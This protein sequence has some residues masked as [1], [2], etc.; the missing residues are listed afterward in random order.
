VQETS[1][2][3][4]ARCGCVRAPHDRLAPGACGRWLTPSARWLTSWTG[5]S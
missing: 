1:K 4:L 2:N 5:R 3:Q